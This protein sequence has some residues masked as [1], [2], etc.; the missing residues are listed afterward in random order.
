MRST[1]LPTCPPASIR[2]LAAGSCVELDHLVDL[3]P[4]AAGR[5]MR[6]HLRHEARHGGRPL[7]LGAQLVRHAEEREP[8]GMQCLAGR[9][10][11][12]ARRRH[13]RP[14][15]AV[16]SK[17]MARMFS[18]KTEPPTAFTTR[19]APCPSVASI[20]AGA[21][22]AARVHRATSRPERPQRLQL[23]RGPGGADD[24]G[25]EHLAELQ[26]S[27]AHSGGHAVDQQPFAG[28]AAGP[29]APAC[30]RTT[31]KVSGMLAASSQDRPA[32]RPWLR[33][34]PSAR[35]RRTRRRSGPSPGRPA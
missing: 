29:A 4:D 16:P 7:R 18:A 6:H 1:I 14:S 28:A 32:G 2:S 22:S 15:R 5:E 34:L 23:L 13:S 21:K 30:R 11:R 27:D 31:R 20:T 8:L 26:R 12:A 25:A 33:P 17:A 9:G 19:S 3:R 24:A 35:T 10:R